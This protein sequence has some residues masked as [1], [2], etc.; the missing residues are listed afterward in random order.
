M[1]QNQQQQ[2]NALTQD[3]FQEPP[4]VTTTKD[5]L[6]LT[7]MMN[8]NLIAAKKAGLFAANCQDPEI[9]QTIIELGKMHER[10][11]NR[12]LQHLSLGA[13]TNSTPT[14]P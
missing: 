3:I 12:F 6:Y 8:W 13:Q 5:A 9:K 10:Q 11:Y 7:D 1:E 4:A 14:A 2:P